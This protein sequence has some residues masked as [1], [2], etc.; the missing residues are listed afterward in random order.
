MRFYYHL[1]LVIR[2]SRNNAC[3][4]EESLLMKQAIT[5]VWRITIEA[6]RNLESPLP[7]L[8]TK[9]TYL[10]PVRKKRNHSR[11]EI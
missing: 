8:F 4:D 9:W 2:L 3:T 6:Y 11:G 1:L 10:L 7:I 5:N